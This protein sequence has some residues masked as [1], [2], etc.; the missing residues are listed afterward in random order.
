MSE[1]RP[2]IGLNYLWRL[3]ATGFC[4]S[5]F[6]LGGLFLT[7]FALP[8]ARFMPGSE[9]QKVDRVR[10]VVSGTFRFFIWLMAAVRC[11]H[12]EVEG[13]ERLRASQGELV[14]A[15]H[16]SLI[17]IVI[18]IAYIPNACCVV[19]QAV[20]RNPFL[21]GVVRWCGYISNSD[22]QALLAQCKQ[23]FENG[24][25]IIVFPEGTRTR[26]A[27]SLKFQRGAANIAVRCGVDILPVTI[28]PDP[29][30]LRK[31][32]PWY[33]IPPHRSIFKV[34]TRPSMALCELVDQQSEPALA[35]RE[36]N[37]YLL[38][39]YQELMSNA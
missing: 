30:T 33:H 5:V 25:S 12:V 3:F 21:G 8:V 26:D 24:L 6:G 29:P 10:Q 39:Y 1:A 7:L 2:P 35:T 34:R 23:T 36:L 17:D 13:R 18:L 28:I 27:K 4:F 9:K 11:I 37:R 19:K 22:P 15:N 20:W 38:N 16:P 14:I 31:G 32:E